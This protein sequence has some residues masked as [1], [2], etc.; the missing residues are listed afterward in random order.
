MD[1]SWVSDDDGKKSGAG[2]KLLTRLLMPPQVLFICFVFHTRFVYMHTCY[3]CLVG[4]IFFFQITVTCRDVN[5]SVK[6]PYASTR[7]KNR[8]FGSRLGDRIFAI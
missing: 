8:V 7:F 6:Y 4:V 1:G 5:E 3:V 2:A